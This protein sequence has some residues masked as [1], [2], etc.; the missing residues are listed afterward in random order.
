MSFP[1]YNFQKGEEW[2]VN[3]NGNRVRPRLDDIRYSK[4]AHKK[5]GMFLTG[6]Q[7]VICIICLLLAFG[8]KTYGG[9][10]YKTARIFASDAM[11]NSITGE[12]ADKVFKIIKSQFPDA[13]EVFADRAASGVSASSKQASSSQSAASSGSSSKT[14]ASKTSSAAVQPQISGSIKT[15]TLIYRENSA[16]PLKTV[17]VSSGTPAVTKIISTSQYK[18][19]VKPV[20]PVKG[21]ITSTF[22]ERINPLTKNESFHTGIDIAAAKDT[23]IAAAY[24]GTVEKT[25]VSSV[26][27]NYVLLNNGGGIE[28]FYGHCDSVTV[29]QGEKV[30][31]GA[32]IAKV[33]S[34][35]QSTG[36]H[37]HFEVRIGGVYVNPQYCLKS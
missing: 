37:L 19:S 7:S 26:Y 24:G 2:G 34:T 9:A 11:K 27:G 28:T 18:L 8:V 30:D 15:D 14:S 35:G 10:I 12:D 33:G 3:E 13:Q 20:V 32:T 31:A 16:V 29:E 21:N 17:K 1:A 5:R 23:P 4:P 25:G 6:F 36:Y 22:G